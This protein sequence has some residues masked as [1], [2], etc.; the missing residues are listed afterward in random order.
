MIRRAFQRRSRFPL[1]RRFVLSVV[2]L[3]LVGALV[4]AVGLSTGMRSPAT[5]APAASMLAFEPS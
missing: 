4:A 1:P 2:S 3:L 5:G